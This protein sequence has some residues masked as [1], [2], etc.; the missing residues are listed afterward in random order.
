MADWL[1]R[2]FPDNT[3]FNDHRRHVVDFVPAPLLAN[4]ADSVKRFESPRISAMLDPECKNPTLLLFVH[5][6]NLPKAP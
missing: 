1:L 4:S 6:R 5:G 2:H 3:T